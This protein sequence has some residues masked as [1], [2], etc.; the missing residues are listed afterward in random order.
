MSEKIEICGRVYK[1]YVGIHDLVEIQGPG[2][3]GIRAVEGWERKV[4]EEI[5]VLRAI[6][7]DQRI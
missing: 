3:D 5:S 1:R 4:V 2:L 7:A 6:V